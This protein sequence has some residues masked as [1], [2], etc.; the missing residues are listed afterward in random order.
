MLFPGQS[1]RTDLA[2][3]NAAR[4]MLEVGHVVSVLLIAGSAVANCGDGT[5]LA[6]DAMWIGVFGGA[7]V[8]VSAIVA[9]FGVRT[10]L[11]SKLEAEIARGNVAAGLAAASHLAATGLLV[12]RAIGGSD[13]ASLGVSLVFFVIAQ[14]TLHL[15]VI[16]FRALTVYDDAEE[17]LGENVAAGLSYAGMTLAV[18]IVIGHAVEGQFAGWSTSLRLYAQAL[19]LAVAFWPV[20]QI[21]VQG[22][23]VGGGM[24]LRGGALDD[25]ISRGKNVGLGALEAGAYVATALLVTRL[26]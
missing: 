21:V 15:F 23:L 16:L 22:L 20:R 2:K 3:G 13:W 18:A 11:E 1:L 14:L 26:G 9:R 6:H 19:L 24:H 25:G 5:D 7:A 8:A 4:A 17:I 10:L 12:S